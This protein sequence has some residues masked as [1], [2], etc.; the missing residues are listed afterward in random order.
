MKLRPAITSAVTALLMSAAA[1]ADNG[2]VLHSNARLYRVR[3]PSAATGRS[4][5]AS[6]AVRALLGK[7]GKTA[8]DVTTGTLDSAEVAPGNISKIQFKGFNGDGDVRWTKNYSGLT[9][10]G[11]LQYTFDDLHRGQPVQTQGN[12]TGIN[13][14]RTDVVTVTGN[15]KLRPDLYLK[16]VD[17]SQQATVGTMVNIA[18]TVSEINGDVGATGNCV[19]LVDGV[20]ADRANG[21]YVDSS[22]AVTCAFTHMF[23]TVGTHALEVRV[24]DVVPGDWDTSNNAA[25]GSI[26]IAS[27]QTPFYWS[28][29]AHKATLTYSSRSAGWYSYSDGTYA[30]GQDWNWERNGA[31]TWQESRLQGYSPAALSFP[32][33]HVTAQHTGDGTVVSSLDLQDVPADWSWGDGSYG[34]RGVS[35]FDPATGLFVYIDTWSWDGRSSTWADTSKYSGDVTYFSHGYANYWYSYSGTTYSYTYNYDD[36]GSFDYWGGTWP[37]TSTATVNL[38]VVD[39]NGV[40]LHASAAIP[41]EPYEWPCWDLPYECYDHNWGWGAEHYCYESHENCSGTYGSVSGAN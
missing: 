6:L 23:D 33:A 37:M 29:W 12:I 10:G 11:T 26:D 34:D 16:K 25:T 4:G 18:S 27:N 3:N 13:G 38:D 17:A 21:I 30:E 40:T 15:V 41:L 9:L 2:P 31:Q 7:D 35:R 8:L 39:A 32:L 36:N 5:S 24:T 19:L 28:A 22:S 1:S 14:Q 20:E